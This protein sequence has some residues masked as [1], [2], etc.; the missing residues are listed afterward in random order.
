MKDKKYGQVTIENRPNA[1]A[2]EPCFVLRGQDILAPIAMAAY[3]DAVEATIPGLQGKYA[4]EH[5][6]EQ[7]KTFAAWAPRKLPDGLV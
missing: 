1:P 4:A 5:I 3:A 2:D 6:R 7:C